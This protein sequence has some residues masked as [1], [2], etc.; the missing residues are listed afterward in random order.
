MAFDQT[1]W[2][3]CR[4]CGKTFGC[5][6]VIQETCEDC[7]QKSCAHEWRLFETG[8]DICRKC[9]CMRPQVQKPT[10]VER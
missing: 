3:T 9:F 1:S 5:G 2:I 4:D 6:C 8:P 10:S 7:R